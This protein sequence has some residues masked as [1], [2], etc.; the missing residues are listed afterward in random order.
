MKK[1]YIESMRE[2]YL[3]YNKK[4]VKWIGHILV[5]NCLQKHVIEGKIE[6]EIVV[7][8]RLGRRYN[9]V[10]DDFKEVRR[11]WKLKE[12]AL[13]HTLRTTCFGRVYGPV[14]KQNTK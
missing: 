14:V 8:G 11:Y 9:Q 6:G 4:K 2:G 3:T 13:D 5:R 12:E 7:M 10:L 1:Y